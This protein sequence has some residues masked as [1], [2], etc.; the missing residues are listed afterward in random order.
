ME[1]RGEKVDVN[2]IR[3]NVKEGMDQMKDRA[4]DFGDE[5][6][7]SAQ[8]IGTKAK[9][10]AEGRGKTWGREVGEAGRRVGVGL[11]HIIGVLFKAFFLS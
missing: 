1:M 5:V 10:F 8:K 6:K 2:T 7:Q 3:Q 4:K 9:E 11:G